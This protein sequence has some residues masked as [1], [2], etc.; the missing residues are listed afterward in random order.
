MTGQGAKIKVEWIN[1]YE[2]GLE[3]ARQKNMPTLLDFFK[4][5]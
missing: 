1:S 3:Q 2:E 4:D 5:G